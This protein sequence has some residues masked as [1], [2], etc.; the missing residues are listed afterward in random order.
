MTVLT[1][2]LEKQRL[3]T[4]SA[5]STAAERVNKLNTLRSQI[6]RYQDVFA[7][8]ASE[9]FGGRPHFESRLIEVIGSLWVLDHARRNLTKWMKPERRSPQALF[10]GPNSLK[11][12]YQPKG[13]VGIISQQSH[14]G[15]D[16]IRLGPDIG[17]DNKARLGYF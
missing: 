2:T 5:P 10:A 1:D 8:A 15:L 17:Y 6:E 7:D 4:R 12:T 13:V 9:D 16:I 11:V 3:A 14:H